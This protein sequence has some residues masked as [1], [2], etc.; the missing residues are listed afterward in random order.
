MD[1]QYENS[2]G[3]I[4]LYGNPLKKP[5]VEIVQKGKEA[6]RNYFESFSET[7]NFDEDESDLLELLL[8]HDHSPLLEAAKPKIPQYKVPQYVEEALSLFEN[9]KEDIL[10]EIDIEIEDEKKR[11]RIEHEL[12]K[13]EN[14]LTKVKTV[15]KSRK[16][17]KVVDVGTKRRLVELVDKI[18]DDDSRI[19]E[20]LEL[21][22]DG[23]EKFNEFADV[24]N[25]FAPV[26]DLPTIS[27]LF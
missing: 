10:E 14:A 24:Y 11:K 1:I 12:K 25:K 22:L 15:A 4:A 18:S 17:V 16:K 2:F 19:V 20:A 8:Q 27:S 5:P 21:I 9:L 13:V 7:A 3:C 23:T 6:I 26:F